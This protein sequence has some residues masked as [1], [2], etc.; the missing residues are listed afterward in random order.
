MIDEYPINIGTLQGVTS[1][2]TQKLSKVEVSKPLNENKAELFHTAVDRGLFLCKRSRLDVQPTIA[3]LCTR[4][5]QPNKVYWNKLLRLM[6]YLVG[7]REFWST[8]K[9]DKTS[10]LKLYVDAEF[11]VHLYF[12]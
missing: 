6:K 5:K 2:K 11:V 3:L 4:A 8:L 7:T 10:C 9:S 1:L 12:K